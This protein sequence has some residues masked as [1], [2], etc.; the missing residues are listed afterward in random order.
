MTSA[1][2]PPVPAWI[3]RLPARPLCDVPW[4]GRSVILSDGAVNFCCFSDA[5]VGN[6]HEQPLHEIWRGPKMQAIRQA[7]VRQRLPPECESTSCPIYR[8]DAHTYLFD[9]MDGRFRRERTGTDD[10]HAGAR[11]R[12][13][14]SGLEVT[15]PRVKRGTP[16]GA[17]LT[18]AC[19]LEWLHGDLFLSLTFP[20]RQL[21]FLPEMTEYPLP[22]ARRVELAS[23][24]APVEIDCFDGQNVTAFPKGVYEICAGL[25]VLGSN[26]AILSNC[27]WT[28]RGSFTLT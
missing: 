10:P 17:R 6:V 22:F 1:L 26:P 27:Y 28:A 25:F 18:L 21:R 23:W 13:Q 19:G 14:A 7:L 5:S 8:G 24:L 9:R 16:I 20:G 2:A 11:A 12:L 15:T 3:E 4:L